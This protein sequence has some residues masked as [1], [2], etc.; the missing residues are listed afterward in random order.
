MAVSVATLIGLLL[1]DAVLVSITEVG[2]LA[3]SFGWFAAC[4]SFL[5][6]ERTVRLRMIAALGILV[7]L[8]FV[9]MKIVPGI[10]G[11]FSGAECD[12]PWY[13][14]NLRI[15]SPSLAARCFL[16]SA[17]PRL[18]YTFEGDLLATF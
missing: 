9:A 18:M 16:T 14:A 3:C 8:A 15:H 10:P 5:L 6:V 7:S 2:S 17:I 12:G 4:L 11:H 1:G 13:L